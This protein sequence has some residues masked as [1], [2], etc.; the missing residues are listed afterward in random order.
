M[1]A[2]KFFK[3]SVDNKKI[4]VYITEQEK[5]RRFGSDR[6][7]APFVFYKTGHLGVADPD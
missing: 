2:D 1:A 3:K 7:K 6:S 5:Q 4:K